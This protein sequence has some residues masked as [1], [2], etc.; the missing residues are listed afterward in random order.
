MTRYQVD[1]EAVATTT[2]AVRAAI[3]RI[4][5]EVGALHSQ[6]VNL[7]SSWTGQASS[8]FQGVVTDWKATQQRV[9]ENL[10]NISLALAQAGR[11]YDDIEQQNARLFLR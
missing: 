4:Q 9:E 2:A 3:G 1:S 7:Q 5:G 6:L 8:A 11:V 10:S